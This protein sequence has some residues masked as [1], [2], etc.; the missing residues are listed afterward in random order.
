MNTL[1]KR[2]YQAPLLT[3]ASFRTE[4]GYAGSM[5][6][7][8]LFLLGV[9]DDEPNNIENRQST[10]SYWGGDDEQWL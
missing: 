10:G 2:S 8:M 1:N 3:E 9:F 5:D 4:R 6:L 7:S